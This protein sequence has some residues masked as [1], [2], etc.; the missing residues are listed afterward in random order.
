MHKAHRGWLT[1]VRRSAR[2]AL[3][4]LE[5]GRLDAASNRIRD[6]FLTEGP[7]T[8]AALE[9]KNMLASLATSDPSI[10]KSRAIRNAAMRRLEDVIQFIGN[11]LLATNER[12]PRR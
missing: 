11:A 2:G 12:N 5:Y 6:C 1:E 10:L 4:D 7:T 3:L 8:N 9:V